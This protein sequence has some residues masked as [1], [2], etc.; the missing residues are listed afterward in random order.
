ML[1][2]PISEKILITLL[3]IFPLGTMVIK[4]WMSGLLFA[5][6]TL[7]IVLTINIRKFIIAEVYANRWSQA[8][9]LMLISPILAILIS[10]AIRQEWIIQDYDGP[11]RFL[12][13][14][15][16]FFICWKKNFSLEKYWQ[17]SIPATLI[18]TLVLLPFLPKS[19][20]GIYPTRVTT[21]FIDP[22]TFGRICLTLGLLSLFTIDL[23]EKN[24]WGLKMFKFLGACIGFY[25]SI[26]SGSRTGWLA[27]PFVFFL[28]LWTYGPKNKILSTICAL[29][30]SISA[31]CAA[32]KYSPFI[33]ERVTTTINELNAYNLHSLNI[34]SS[35]GMRI[36]FARMGWY[37]FKLQPLSGWGT[38]G[39][40]NHINDSEISEYASQTAREFVYGAL[41]HNEFITN[42]VKSGIWGIISTALLFFVPLALFISSWRKGISPR[43]AA[44]GIAYVIC[45]LISSMSTEVFNLKFSSS[46][47][48]LFIV[49]LMG[50]ILAN[51]PNL[52]NQILKN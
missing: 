47:Y 3:A 38:K 24:N 15:P 18:V 49:G 32:Y 1:S 23:H 30:I 29:I 43:L 39:Y 37:Y 48:A 40:I 31:V 10:Q 27:M 12:I 36:S 17:Y 21:F 16:I 34:D 51:A 22:L 25:L 8:T 35:A 4:G 52:K 41:F 13:A 46:F 19:G 11:S 2:R 9:L 28:F 7:S 6:A 42:A 26:K 50:S 33:N 14:I 5:C 20:W 45:E 44:L